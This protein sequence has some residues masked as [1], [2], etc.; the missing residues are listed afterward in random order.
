MGY[1]FCSPLL[2]SWG[3]LLEIFTTLVGGACWYQSQFKTP[4]LIDSECCNDQTGAE[5][6]S[7]HHECSI[8]LIEKCH[9]PD[10]QSYAKDSAI[11]HEMQDQEMAIQ[12]EPYD[13]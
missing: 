10:T 11:E 7:N 4:G 12:G 13:D 1:T 6:K 2:F 8:F 3:C 9:S 5:I